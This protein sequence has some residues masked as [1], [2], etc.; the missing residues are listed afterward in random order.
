MADLIM[1]SRRAAAAAEAIAAYARA[2]EPCGL[3]P[4]GIL[5]RMAPRITERADA[6][7]HAAADAAEMGHEHGV[8]GVAPYCR[9][10]H[11]G[12]DARLMD[13]FGETEP[14]TNANA[15]HRLDL[16]QAYA[17]AYRDTRKQ[18]GVTPTQL[19]ERD[20]RQEPGGPAGRNIPP[21][22]AD[23]ARATSQAEARRPR[24][25]P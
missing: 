4:P 6:I 19:P 18:V 9:L 14:T 10:D 11:D 24:K 17:T 8:A 7:G 23:T 2:S 3:T 20:H 13:E 12:Q 21:P 22:S 1:N 25:R 15:M 5:R 16:V